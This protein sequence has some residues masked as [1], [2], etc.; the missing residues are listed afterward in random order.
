MKISE[1]WL[2]EFASPPGD[3][4][5]LV[6]QLTMQGLEVESIESAGP[7]LD[8]VVVGLV[9]DVAPHPDADRLRVCQ[10]DIGSGTV[11][12]VCGAP[13]VRP[14][15]LYPAALPGATLPGG[16]EIGKAILRGVQS[17]G[18]L[19][20]ASELGLGDPGAS[21]RAEG[22]LELD[23]GGLPG[24]PVAPA[25]A[26]PDTILDLKIT[27]NRADCFSVVG[28]AR[29]LA[30]TAGLAFV[31]P[32]SP[33]VPA[34]GG[35]LVPVRVEDPAGSPAFLVRAVR[36]IHPG[37]R[38]PFWL[39]ERLRR[40]GIRSIHPVVD[41]TNLVMLEL[42]QPLHAYDL[43][44]LDGGLIVRRARES[45]PIQLLTGAEVRLDDDCLVI[46]DG[47]GAIGLAG[48]MGGS[49]TAVSAST[50][51]VLLE[52]AYFAP[53]AISGRA[54]RLGLQTDASTRFER[55]VDPN[56][57][58]RALERATE[59]LL[60]IAGG[61]P[62]PCQ[63][64]G[65][66]AANR[67]PVNLRRARLARVLGEAVP[68]PE[69]EGILVRLGMEVTPDGEGWQVQPPAFRFD[70]SIEVDLIEEIA[71][72]HGYDRIAPRPGTQATKLG[73]APST[74]VSPDI[75]RAVLV[76]RGYQEAITYSFVDRERDR[77]LAGG[78]EGVP[79]ANPLTADLAVMR[80]SL[81]PGLIQA[82]GHNLSRQQRRVRLFEAGV[83]FIPGA[84][85]MA[86]ES[87]LAGIAVGTS[88]PEQWGEPARSTDFHDVK[89]DLQAV[90]A[91][92]GAAGEFDWVADTHPA[93]QPGRTARVRRRGQHLGWLGY[94]H[95]SLVKPCGLEE[96]PLLFE[97]NLGSLAAATVTA[98]QEL[99]RFPAVRRD[100][101]VLVKRDTPVGS[102]VGA[103][104]DAA[105]PAL[106]EVVVFDIFAGEHIDAGE[107]S[108]ALGLILQET[109]RTLTDAETD[110]I[111]GGVVQRL[112]RD[113]GARMRE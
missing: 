63:A 85:G 68:D 35:D 95:P 13:N 112:A 59:L 104:T 14:G 58:R 38:S 77:L 110:N 42:G 99:S 6:H 11:Q 21:G 5:A 109:S 102:L 37:A 22:L 75:L 32:V 113:F 80:Q 72:V 27:P 19:C 7:A 18:M 56:G 82:L 12:I 69:V 108:V 78:R 3:T 103:V 91:V 9:Q 48:I 20:S 71:R 39:R 53:S 111:V 45:E 62:G 64:E 41:I 4:A 1:S 25:L 74:R 47:S 66:R 61:A 44:R 17:G 16:L 26:L 90:L 93:L 87:V 105:G 65:A 96:A 33:A 43:D 2:R 83:R 84:G 81:W 70:I 106:R 88:V 67:P 98:Y 107:K 97:L 28:V 89:A 40:S 8:G 10:V 92:V 15:G 73:E 30:A 79:L 100:V 36:G 29:D 55:G 76:Q 31:E 23:A 60:A 86:E 54:R 34:C 57:Q 46:A 101:A 94:L 49:G 24:S 51:N 50:T 52:S